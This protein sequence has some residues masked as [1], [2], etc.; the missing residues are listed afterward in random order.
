MRAPPNHA[1]F[2]IIVE[3]IPILSNFSFYFRHTTGG[4]SDY[5]SHIVHMKHFLFIQQLQNRILALPLAK[6]PYVLVEED[7]YGIMVW[8]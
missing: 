6:Q 1:N 5:N 7:G 2:L 4:R 3:T 8:F